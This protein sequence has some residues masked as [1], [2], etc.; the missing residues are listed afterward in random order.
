MVCAVCL[1]N[2]GPFSFNII[3]FFLFLLRLT[4][5]KND[6]KKY[7]F[8]WSLS[9]L[10]VSWL[11]Y[12]YMNAVVSRIVVFVFS[13]YDKKYTTEKYPTEKLMFSAYRI[14]NDLNND[15]SFCVEEEMK[16]DCM[17]HIYIVW[18]GWWREWC[19][20]VH[21]RGNLKGS[22]TGAS[23]IKINTMKIEEW[24][25]K[26]NIFSVGLFLLFRWIV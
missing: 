21:A 26:G 13:S 24:R 15:V 8:Y 3:T 7:T 18:W 5:E 11:Y 14:Q 4:L 22:L 23:T 12:I 25:K 20:G 2:I 1:L 17:W 10:V 9:L 19:Y 6:A 16:E